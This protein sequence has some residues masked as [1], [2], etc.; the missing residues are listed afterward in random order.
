M[1]QSFGDLSQSSLSTYSFVIPID[2]GYSTAVLWNTLGDR[3]AGEQG[4]GGCQENHCLAHD[5]FWWVDSVD[6]HCTERTSRAVLPR[7]GAMGG[8]RNTVG[9]PLSLVSFIGMWCADTR[10]VSLL[11]LSHPH[12]HTH[13]RTHVHSWSCSLRCSL[14]L[15]PAD[16]SY[17][18]SFWHPTYTLYIK[19][20]REILAAEGMTNRGSFAYHFP[21]QYTNIKWSTYRGMYTMLTST[22]GK[23]PLRQS[24]SIVGHLSH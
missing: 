16:V 4:Q 9:L 13:S 18:L 20:Y 8:S 12:T 3:L 15:T 2:S 10:H 11:A 24:R 5:H 22:C 6:Y 14:L 19:I 7:V 23:L 1:C 17:R 21:A